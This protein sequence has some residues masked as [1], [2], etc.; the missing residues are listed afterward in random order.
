MSFSYSNCSC[1]HPVRWSG[2]DL[3]WWSDGGTRSHLSSVAGQ[4]DDGKSSSSNPVRLLSFCTLSIFFPGFC[5]FYFSSVYSCWRTS[6]CTALHAPSLFECI[7]TSSLSSSR[8]PL[9]E[10]SIIG[11]HSCWFQD[12]SEADRLRD[13]SLYLL[14]SREYIC[15]AMTGPVSVK[16]IKD[17]SVFLIV[18][19][20]FFSLHFFLLF[21]VSSWDRQA[22]WRN[23]MSL[24]ESAPK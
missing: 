7:R 18:C 11:L 14:P 2:V 22:Q 12:E 23:W 13:L 24:R 21:C 19:W 9:P 10:L 16:T 1:R 17:P 15:T 20:Y 8:W 3:D 6:L 5:F 4:L